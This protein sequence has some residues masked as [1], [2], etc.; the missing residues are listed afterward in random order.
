MFNIFVMK[1]KLKKVTLELGNGGTV[2]EKW[3]FLKIKFNVIRFLNNQ[4]KEKDSS[5][6]LEG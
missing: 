5:K 1:N 6:I 4:K 3:K 2:Q